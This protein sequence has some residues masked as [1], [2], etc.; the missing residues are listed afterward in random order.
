MCGDACGGGEGRVKAPFGG[1][2]GELDLCPHNTLGAEFMRNAPCLEVATEAPKLP[3][4][5]TDT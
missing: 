3:P 2:S 4:E 1:G 5:E